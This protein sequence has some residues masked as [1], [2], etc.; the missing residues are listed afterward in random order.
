MAERENMVELINS[1]ESLAGGQ[2]EI[3]FLIA[4]FEHLQE[5]IRCRNRLGYMG[6]KEVK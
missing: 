4:T 3:L 5:G 2:G 6:K 1:R